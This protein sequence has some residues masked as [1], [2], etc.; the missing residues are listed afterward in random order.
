MSSTCLDVP[1]HRLQPAG[2]VADDTEL[3]ELYDF[4]PDLDRPF[5]KVN[6]I[7]SLD[8]AVS[9]GGRSGGLS[10][11]NDKRVF[12]LGRALADVIL[13]G[14]QTAVI[15]RYKGVRPEEVPGELRARLGLAPVP[16]I[17][18]VT[19]RA[20][21]DPS[22]ALIRSAQ[23]PTIVFTSELAP[24]DHRAA[25]AEAGADV[26]VTGEDHVDHDVVLA[27]LDRR[28]LRRVT[29]EG[30][31]QLFGTMIAEGKV[32]ELDLSLSPLLVAGDAGRIA[33]GGMPD[34]PLRM[35]PASV[36]RADGML[37]IRYVRDE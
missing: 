25:L 35:K 2:H 31:P 26:V 15:E 20:S 29:C 14:A 24:A 11:E 16:P 6:F 21:I 7:C 12:R 9:L 37:L 30:G 13:V 32:D 34:V 1:V 18:V 5:V 28:A 3:T 36:L 22:A 23:A 19:R 8:G 10:D 27:E 33:H 4:P 17:A